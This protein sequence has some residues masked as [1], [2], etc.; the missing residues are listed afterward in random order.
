M[1]PAAKGFDSRDVEYPFP[2]HNPIDGRYYMYYL[3][4]QQMPRSKQTGLLV[5]EGDLG[6]W[7]RIGSGPVVARAGSHEESGC[8]HPSVT[9]DGDTIHMVYTGEQPAPPERKEILYN[10]PTICHATAPISDPAHVTKNPVNPVFSGSGQGWDRYG[11]REAEIL[12]G[13]GYFDIFYGGYDGTEWT[14]GHV[15]TRDFIKFEPNP[16]NPI[17]RPSSNP[18]A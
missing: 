11:V 4:N 18:Q 6:S 3:G 1:S 10:V 15:R 17:F 9:V 14:I 2:F 12:K 8:S 5:S 16:H 7:T 13:P